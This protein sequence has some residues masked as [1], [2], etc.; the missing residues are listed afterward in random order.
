M[1]LGKIKNLSKAATL[2]YSRASPETGQ[3]LGEYFDFPNR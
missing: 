2:A 3:N 1:S